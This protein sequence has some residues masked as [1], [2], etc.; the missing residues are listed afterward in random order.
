M[1]LGG[2]GGLCGSKERQEPLGR[3]PWGTLLA[4]PHC[5]SWPHS[6]QV[7]R[8]VAV[9]LLRARSPAPARPAISGTLGRGLVPAPAGRGAPG[10]FAC[11]AAL[12]PSEVLVG[13]DPQVPPTVAMGPGVAGCQ[14]LLA[15]PFR[16]SGGLGLLLRPFLPRATLKKGPGAVGSWRCCASAL[17]SLHR[18]WWVVPPHIPVLLTLLSDHSPDGWHGACGRHLC[19]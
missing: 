1:G 2:E 11:V 18:S 19:P 17:P 14:Q 8:S 6:L 3:Q 12:R 15:D 9:A 7:G 4:A 5:P 10:Q 16:P 13:R